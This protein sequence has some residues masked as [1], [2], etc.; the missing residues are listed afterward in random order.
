MRTV[1]RYKFQFYYISLSIIGCFLLVCFLLSDLDL[2]QEGEF[3]C[4]SD[5]N[6]ESCFPAALRCNGL[7]DVCDDGSDEFGCKCSDCCFI[8]LLTSWLDL[9]NFAQVL[10]MSECTTPT[11]CVFFFVI[12]CLKEKMGIKRHI[13]S[14]ILC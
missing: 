1:R 9:F 6:T 4:L 11:F 7:F 14:H 2:C 5:A 8:D 13:F 10:V 12:M 3:R